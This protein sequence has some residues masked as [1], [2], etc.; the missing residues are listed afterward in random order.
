MQNPPDPR[1]AITIGIAIAFSMLRIQ[2][3]PISN[4]VHLIQMHEPRLLN[5]LPGQK[6][7]NHDRDLDVERHKVDGLEGRA[8]AGPALHEDQDDIQ[9][10]GDDG[11]DGVR[12]VLEGEE[13][14]E[15]LPADGGAEAQGGDADADPRDLVGDADDAGSTVRACL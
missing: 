6:H 1:R 3:I 11:A 12:P 5:Q 8:E 7:D 10:D 9:P 4:Q 13:M 14:L 15:V 2:I